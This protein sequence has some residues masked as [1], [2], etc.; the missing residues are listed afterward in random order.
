[1]TLEIVK[2]SCTREAERSPVYALFKI[3]VDSYFWIVFYFKLQYIQEIYVELILIQIT[4]TSR[5][6]SFIFN[7]HF[8]QS[9]Y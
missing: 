4:N 8:Y 6:Q 3:E 2:D 5:D 7:Q 9:S 1:M